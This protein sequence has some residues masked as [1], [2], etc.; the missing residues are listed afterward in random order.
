MTVAE[1]RA[2]SGPSHTKRRH[3]S[4]ALG[5]RI[6]KGEVEP[7]EQLPNETD[8]VAELGVGRGAVREA[9]KALEAKGLLESRPRTGTRVKDRDQ[10]NFLDADVLR[11]MR[12]TRP[13][14]LA[15]ELSD[16]R[17]AIE[18]QAAAL[19]ARRATKED[20]DAIVSAYHRMSAAALNESATF[21]EADM[22]FH[23]AILEGT[24]NDLFVSLGHAIGVALFDS[25]HKG[26]EAPGAVRAS[27]PR[28]ELVLNA[29]RVG[30]GH[31]ASAAALGLV[32][33][34]MHDIS[35]AGPWESA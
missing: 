19:A 21:V 18:P 16:L 13:D 10:W 20:L 14:R 34:S 8:L 9:V 29:I 35:V 32:A 5:L 6:L 26:M 15:E 22:D 3:A 7:G 11:W 25:F 28:H 30:D 27:L 24:H 2:R 23:L 4:D 12:V 1:Q 33:T 17:G 31:A